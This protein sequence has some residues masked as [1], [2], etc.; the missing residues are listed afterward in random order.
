MKQSWSTLAVK[1][2]VTTSIFFICLKSFIFRSPSLN[3]P[4]HF[5]CLH[6]LI[7][8]FRK[9]F[10][11]GYHLTLANAFLLFVYG[12]GGLVAK[13]CPTLAILWTVAG[14]A[15]VSVILQVRILNWIA[16]SFSRGS[17]WSRN[18]TQV[19]FIAGKFFT[20]WAVREATFVCGYEYLWKLGVESW[21][22]PTAR[23]I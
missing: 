11:N 15:P 2:Q 5:I 7:S 12:G 23:L 19:S 4:F 3:S 6:T 20:D 14:Q 22:R 8:N 17:S 16:I 10:M 1:K 21:I 18:W 13:L 9:N